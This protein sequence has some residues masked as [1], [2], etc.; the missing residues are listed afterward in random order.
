MLCR[1]VKETILGQ[2]AAAFPQL[3]ALRWG[4]PPQQILWSGSRIST[5]EAHRWAGGPEGRGTD[6]LT[7][8]A[9]GSSKERAPAPWAATVPGSY[10]TDFS[11]RWGESSKNPRTLRV[12]AVSS[13]PHTRT[14]TKSYAEVESS[15]KK[16]ISTHVVKVK[17][18]AQA[19]RHAIKS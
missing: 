11:E 1:K 15:R 6:L 2:V 9:L 16:S 17:R 13:V 8:P 19:W 4:P 18:T 10:T 3:S 12:D 14:F 5:A 7:I